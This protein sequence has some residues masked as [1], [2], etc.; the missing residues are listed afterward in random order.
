MFQLRRCFPRNIP[1]AILL[2]CCGLFLVGLGVAGCVMP[3][4]ATPRV[5]PTLV[6]AIPTLTEASSTSTPPIAY[7]DDTLSTLKNN[8]VPAG[9]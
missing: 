9:D 4:S 3:Q 8:R 7:G 2:A 6:E 1:F 5:E